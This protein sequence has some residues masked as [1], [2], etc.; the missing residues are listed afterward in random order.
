MIV[1]FFGLIFLYLASNILF[2]FTV[3]PTIILTGCTVYCLVH[4]TT[5]TT[6]VL[7]NISRR[8]QKRHKHAGPV[9]GDR[10]YIRNPSNTREE[11]CGPSCDVCFPNSVFHVHRDFSDLMDRR[12]DG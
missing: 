8:M 3:I 5:D 6:Y 11:H 10:V 4:T 7:Q 2:Y 12:M 9:G 1:I